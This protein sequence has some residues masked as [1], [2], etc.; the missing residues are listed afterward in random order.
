MAESPVFILGEHDAGKTT[1]FRLMMGEDEFERSPA[2]CGKPKEA[3]VRLGGHW[4]VSLFL[5]RERLRI[6]DFA[7]NVTQRA[8]IEGQISA[9]LKEHGLFG[10]ELINVF[11]CIDGYKL[12]GEDADEREGIVTRCRADMDLVARVYAANEIE[13]KRKRF[14]IVVTRGDEPIAQ[15]KGPDDVQD[16]LG[17]LVKDGLSAVGGGDDRMLIFGL[18]DQKKREEA[19]DK[20]IDIK[21]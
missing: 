11:Y 2:T 17:D 3:D 5:N 16:A 12:F 15:G 4:D 14:Y 21:F 9:A 7:G 19:F 6:Y 1:L 8:E 18:C 20:L 13:D 10:D